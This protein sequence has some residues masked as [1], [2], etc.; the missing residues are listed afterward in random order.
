MTTFTL[1]DGSCY[2]NK[3]GTGEWH[4]VETSSEY[5]AWLEAG[6]TPEPAPEPPPEMTPEQKLAASG[7]SVED[8][9]Q[10]LGLNS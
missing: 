8:L 2:A 4:H 7:L 10:L 5:L 3:V 9:R 6:N 1:S